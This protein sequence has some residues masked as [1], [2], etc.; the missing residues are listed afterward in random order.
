M[1]TSYWLGTSSIIESGKLLVW[2][3]EMWSFLHKEHGT[4]YLQQEELKQVTSLFSD[5]VI[6]WLNAINW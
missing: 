5:G 6:I 1:Y 3:K 2:F 4:K